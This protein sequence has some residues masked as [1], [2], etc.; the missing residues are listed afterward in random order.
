MQGLIQELIYQKN[1]V[2]DVV[3]DKLSLSDYFTAAAFVA[4]R[5]FDGPHILNDLTYGRKDI[6]SEGE[7]GNID[8]LAS[9][10]KFRSI[11]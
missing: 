1:H 8:N 5:E 6:E 11:L 3:C 10:N 9:S 4:L 7:V 2:E